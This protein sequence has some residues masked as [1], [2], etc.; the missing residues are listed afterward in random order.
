VTIPIAPRD[1]DKLELTEADRVMLDGGFGPVVQQAMRI[2]C[3][4]AAQQGAQALV[5]VSQ[6]HIDGCIYASAANLTFAERMAELGARS[7]VPTTTNAISVDHDNWR[8]QGVPPSFGAPASRL[9]DA[10]VRMGCR[11]TYTCSPYLLDGA[12]KA[13]EFVGWSES[14]AVIFANSVLGAR[15]AK[16]ADFLDLCIALTGRAPLSG[17]YL[18]SNRKARRVIDVERPGGADDSFWPLVGYLAGRARPDRIPL[19]RGLAD[20]KPSRDDLKALCAAFGT[21]SAGTG[22][23]QR[24]MW[25]CFPANGDFDGP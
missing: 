15:T 22:S 21:T 4:M 1:A 5:D 23:A 3:A 19:L 6:V 24:R 17:V 10:Y 7:R 12:P 9:A 25:Y 20:A 2:L 18:D 11:P 8:A 16:H 14:N 13:G